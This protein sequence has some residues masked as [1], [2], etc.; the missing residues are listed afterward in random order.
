MRGK[1]GRNSEREF[2]TK[3]YNIASNTDATVGG[4]DINI[5]SGHG[6]TVAGGHY[7]RAL[8]NYSAIGGGRIDSVSGQYSVV[9]G[10]RNNTVSGDYSLAFGYEVK[11]S[12]DYV[13]A[14][15]TDDY[16]GKLGI[17]E[18]SPHSTL[19]SDGSLALPIVEEDSDDYDLGDGDYTV[20]MEDN[21]YS[22]FLPRPDGIKGRIYVIKNKHDSG[23]SITLYCN[24]AGEYID[25]TAGTSGISIA[26]GECRMVQSNGDDTWYILPV[27]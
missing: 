7:C 8:G 13:T 18:P 24:Y 12:D 1:T 9:P 21:S 15:Y 11:V 20:V 27:K 2:F 19:H 10:G 17:N 6:A 16:P 26:Q 22:V 5:A 23:G 25:G 14:F 3:Q 4:G